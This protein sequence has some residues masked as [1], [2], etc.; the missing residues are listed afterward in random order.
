LS[1]YENKGGAPTPEQMGLANAFGGV[2]KE[3]V[4]KLEISLNIPNLGWLGKMFLR[5]T[6]GG[7]VTPESQKMGVEVP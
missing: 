5:L 6:T 1:T 3:I 4:G 2:I 7:G